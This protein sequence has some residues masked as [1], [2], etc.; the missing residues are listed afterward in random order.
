MPNEPANPMHSPPPVRP[1]TAMEEAAKK[2]PWL[3]R[4][5]HRMRTVSFAMLFAAT[6]LHIYG[7][8]YGLA[9]WAALGL[10]LLVYPHVQCWRASRAADPVRAE[11]AN[12]LVDSIL[13][14]M[15]AAA[16][17][18]PL[19]LSFS[20]ALGTLINNAANKGWRGVGQTSL[21]LP[22]GALAWIAVGGFG[23]SPHTDWP[24][25]LFCI[26]GLTGYVVAVGSIG[27][28]RNIQL[29]VAR[30]ALKSHE[31]EL[32]TANETLQKKL[33][34]IDLLQQ[35]LREQAMRDPLTGLYNRRYLDSTLE[36]ELAR[37][38]REGQSLSLILI[39]I[40]RFKNI[41]DTYGHQA[42]DEVLRRLGSVL[43][44]ASRVED[45]ACR[46]GGEEFLVLMPTMSLPAARLRAEE[47]RASVGATEI[48]FGSFRLGVTLS[49]GISVYPGHG[50]SA[51]ELVKRADLALYKAKQGGRNQI[52]IAERL[53][54]RHGQEGR[55]RTDIIKLVWRAAFECGHPLLDEQHR[56]LFGQVNDLISVLLSEHRADEVGELIDGVVREVGQHFREEELLIT[57]AGFP[58]A[59]EHAMI[60]AEL[61][62][63]AVLLMDRFK[64]EDLG[65]GELVQFLAHDLI[66]RHMLGADREFFS[67]LDD[68][69]GE[70]LSVADS[71]SG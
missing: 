24:V 25:T 11:M 7:K 46:Y 30:E 1:G 9:A 4:I 54:L 52:R 14:G 31:K 66:V 43:A 13:L 57:A 28:K 10:L 38:K 29:R 39:D 34:E 23:F 33:Q 19:W 64:G 2:C 67:Y 41:N 18:F 40:D 3:V 26:A 32:L 16:L 48:P 59:R 36:R 61:I 49:I 70:A 62:D 42:G 50:M 8:G 53:R 58:G 44:A 22:A 68:G 56:T 69:A 60:H 55:G 21:A 12:L 63:R 71:Q 65:I 27:F 17:E 45:V 37:C 5:H 35:Q 6:G 51:D 47:L 20:A 15:F